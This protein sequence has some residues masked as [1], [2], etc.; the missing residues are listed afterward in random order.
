[1]AQAG[2]SSSILLKHHCKL[3]LVG[4]T[5]YLCSIKDVT[6]D[7]SIDKIDLETFDMER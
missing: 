6:V 2:D 4:I 1:M 5:S 7:S 3:K